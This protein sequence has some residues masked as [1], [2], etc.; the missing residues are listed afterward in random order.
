MLEW[1][2]DLTNKPNLIGILQAD[3]I[4][5]FYNFVVAYFLGH[6]VAYITK[7]RGE[8]ELMKTNAFSHWAPKILNL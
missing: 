1:Y 8:R 5:F 7:L 4:R 2:F 6:P 3:L